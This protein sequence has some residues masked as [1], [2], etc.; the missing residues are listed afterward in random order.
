MVTWLFENRLISI[1]VGEVSEHKAPSMLQLYMHLRAESLV[2]KLAK[3]IS[4]GDSLDFRLVE[5]Q[6]NTPKD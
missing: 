6:G 4:I 3:I 1:N 2:D 5:L